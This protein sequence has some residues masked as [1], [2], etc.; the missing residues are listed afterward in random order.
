MEE[1]NSVKVKQL[2]IVTQLPSS[3]CLRK[4]PN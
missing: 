4:R 1:I 2:D 3:K